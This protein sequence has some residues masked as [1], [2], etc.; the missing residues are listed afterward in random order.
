MKKKHLK[1]NVLYIF[2]GEFRIQC[3]STDFFCLLLYVAKPYSFRSY[4][5][6]VEPLY[7]IPL[8]MVIL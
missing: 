4:S 8:V 2:S 7:S 6:A 1:D 5:S 3:I